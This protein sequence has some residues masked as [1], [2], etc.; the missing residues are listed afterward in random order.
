[1]GKT[2]GVLS[3]KG[4]VGKTSSV[5]ALGSALATLGKKV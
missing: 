4:G 3:L 5:V 1:M 2:I